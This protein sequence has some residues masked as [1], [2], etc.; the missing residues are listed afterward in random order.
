MRRRRFNVVRGRAEPSASALPAVAPAHGGAPEFGE[1][2]VG[3][4]VIPTVTRVVA[5]TE[6]TG[7]GRDTT[8]RMRITLPR[9]RCL[10]RQEASAQ[11]APA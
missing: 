5:V 9:L 8:H 1:V 2:R 7:G 3:G 4:L 6:R 10:E 11:G